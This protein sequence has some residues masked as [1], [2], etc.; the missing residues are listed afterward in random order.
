[1]KHWSGKDFE[2]RGY[3]V[4]NNKKDGFLNVYDKNNNYLFRVSSLGH[5]CIPEVKFH[6]D[7]LISRYGG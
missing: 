6:I 2:Y 5:G 1:M 4:K 7:N 3:M